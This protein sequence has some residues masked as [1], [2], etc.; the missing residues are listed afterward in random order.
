MIKKLLVSAMLYG[1]LI[2]T[3][4]NVVFSMENNY[5]WIE[6]GEHHKEKDASVTQELH[7][8]YGSFPDY[9]TTLLHL[10]EVKG[11]YTMNEI[12]TKGD[13][14]YYPLE[15]IEEKGEVFIRITSH[16][17]NPFTVL[18]QGEKNNK[19]QK[20]IYLAKTSFFLF[21]N[22]NKKQVES[23]LFTSNTVI[24]IAENLQI[25]INP[26]YSY[27][28]Q[29][30]TPV[31]FN[32]FFDNQKLKKKIVHIIDENDE[33]VFNPITRMTD[34]SGELIYIPPDDRKLRQKGSTAY[35]Q[36]VIMAE[37]QKE[38]SIYVSSFTLLLHRSRFKHYNVPVGV[39]IFS[40]LLTVFFVLMLLQRKGDIP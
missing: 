19:K 27:W 22:S 38:N 10:D 7:I 14:V 11:V 17:T 34:E 15:I 37:E 23:E 4:N 13:V 2:S 30:D 31:T 9:K 32:V 5:L 24:K 36:I 39:I 40:S 3:G 26:H 33:N 6:F 21:G 12:D 25:H 28:R 18:I 1:L 35:K 8:Y 16:K 20:K 29:V